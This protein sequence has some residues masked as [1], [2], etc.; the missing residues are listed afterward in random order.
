MEQYFTISDY[1][2]QEVPICENGK[3]IKLT[4]LNLDKWVKELT[5]FKLHKEIER[6]LHH[7]KVGFT[8][9][10][11]AIHFENFESDEFNILLGGKVIYP[12][13]L[14]PMVRKLNFN[15]LYRLTSMSQIN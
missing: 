1:N 2:G 7:F 10:I 3:E 5:R 4:N 6:Q 13:T 9:I 11:P 12:E 14:I 8:K 15:Y